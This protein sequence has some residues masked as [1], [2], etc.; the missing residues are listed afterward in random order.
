MVHTSKSDLTK[1]IIEYAQSI[2]VAGLLAAII[3]IFIAQSFVV[4]GESMEATLHDGQR[5][6]I[7]KISYRFHEPSRGDIIVLKT[8]TKERYIKRVIGLPGDTIQVKA[9]GYT[10]VNSRRVTNDFTLEGT[11]GI[12]PPP[13]EGTQY[14]VPKDHVFVMG[15]NRNHSDDSRLS[16]GYLAEKSIVGRACV[17][18]WPPTAIGLVRRPDMF[19]KGAEE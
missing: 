8:T 1:E 17:R 13:Q 11:R 15:D 6:L 18:F 16:V 5:L 7:E 2:A 12:W 9:D 4:R 19:A 10:Y 14:R 3:I